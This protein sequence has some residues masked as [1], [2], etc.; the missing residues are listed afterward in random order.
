MSSDDDDIELPDLIPRPETHPDDFD[1]GH[2]HPNPHQINLA[3][4]QKCHTSLLKEMTLHFQE[5]DECPP[6]IDP[7][8]T[9]MLAIDGPNT[10][11]SSDDP[12]DRYLPE[13]QYLKAVLKLA[14]LPGFMLFA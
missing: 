11:T 7:I 12:V 10:S 3:Q 2:I 13:P 4:H 9:A 6:S 1:H 8:H 5:C 14:D